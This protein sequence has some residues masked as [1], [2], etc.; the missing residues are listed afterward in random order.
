M[1]LFLACLLPI[2]VLSFRNIPSSHNIIKRISY[3]DNDF[4]TTRLFSIGTDPYKPGKQNDK[5]DAD[6]IWQT[7]P[8][9]VVPIETERYKVRPQL[10]TFEAFDTLL[11]PSQSV[12]RW[13]REVLNM[14]C[15]FRIRLPRPALF[16][17]AYKKAY[18]EMSRAH[19]CFG[20]LSGM[21]SKAWW[22]N[23][24]SQTYKTTKDLNLIKDH[25]FEAMLPDLVNTLYN[26]VF[27]TKEGWLLKEDT[28]YTLEKLRAWRDMGSGP[29]IGIVSNYDER[30]HYILEDL[31]IL[32]SFDF[33][34]TSFETQSEKPGREIFDLALKAAKCT[35]PDKAFHIGF[36]VDQD[37]KGA[38]ASGWNAVRFNEW[39]DEDFPDWFATDTPQTA[40]EGFE[41]RA[42]FQH[43]GRRDTE[44]GLEWLELW[45]LDDILFLFGLPEDDERPL[46]TTYIRGFRDD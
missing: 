45:G 41:R 11:E 36:E 14:K 15:K 29:K 38:M 3:I 46:R 31:G 34:L 42:A 25:E 18:F 35:E 6:P 33:V 13:L 32:D 24:I 1:N 9:N 21:T 17:A 39:F 19:P 28:L 20:A 5:R 44:K 37:V 26:N 43:W 2:Y 30:L 22:F 27:G 7:P 10:I 4:S 40:N 16:T 8:S 12:G 23:V